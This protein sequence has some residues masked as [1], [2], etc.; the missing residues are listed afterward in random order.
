MKLYN[1]GTQAVHDLP[2]CNPSNNF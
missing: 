1:Y 2:P